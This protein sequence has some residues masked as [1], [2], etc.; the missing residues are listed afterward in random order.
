MINHKSIKYPYPNTPNLLLIS[1]TL[2]TEL[3]F[4]LSIQEQNLNAD[5]ENLVDEVVQV[6]QEETIIVALRRIVHIKRLVR[7]RGRASG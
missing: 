6:V 2:Y 5:H 3:L 4:S 1:P 7:E